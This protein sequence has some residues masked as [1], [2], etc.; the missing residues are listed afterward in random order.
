MGG[1]RLTGLPSPNSSKATSIST[2]QYKPDSF[3]LNVIKF[4]IID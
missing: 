3:Y 4:I 2:L 1:A